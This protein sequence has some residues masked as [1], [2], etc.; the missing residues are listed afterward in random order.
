MEMEAD[1]RRHSPCFVGHPGSSRAGLAGVRI[2]YAVADP[3]LVSYM[4]AIKQPYNVNTAAEAAALA[5][6]KH[7]DKIMGTV[8]ALRREKD[9][10]YRMLLEVGATGG[11]EGCDPF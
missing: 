3:F 9:R 7:R 10:L 6:L 4:L 8:T 1:P 5:A 11:Y 2:G